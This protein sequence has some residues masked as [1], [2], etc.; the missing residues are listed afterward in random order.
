MAI[1]INAK[2]Y[3]FGTDVP[4]QP[5][6][7]KRPSGTSPEPESSKTTKGGSG[8]GLDLGG[9][10]NFLRGLDPGGVGNV[11]RGF[12][13]ASNLSNGSLKDKEAIAEGAS[14]LKSLDPAGLGKYSDLAQQGLGFA[15]NVKSGS[16]KGTDAAVAGLNLAG[17]LDP[18]GLGP[19][20]N[21]AG[22]GIDL[23]KNVKNGSLK[24]TDAAVASL[25][26]AG[27]LDP[28]G[29]GQYANIAGQGIDFAKNV[30]SGS[31][32]GADA[33]VSGLGLAGQFDPD[34]LGK[35]ANVAGQGLSFAKDV[36]SGSLQGADAAASGLNLAG[37]VIGGEVGQK[38][39][40]GGDIASKVSSISANTVPGAATGNVIGLGFNALQL[41][42]IKID[43][44]VSSLANLGLSLAAGPVGWIG[45]VAQIVSSLFS[46]GDHNKTV[47]MQKGI[48]A[49]GRIPGDEDE[50][51][52]EDDAP[53]DTSSIFDHTNTGFL[54]IGSSHSSSM[55]YDT[56]GGTIDPRLL[57]D[58]EF[59][60]D[61]GSSGFLG[62]GS[63]KPQLT[64]K[65]NY[66]GI[67]PATGGTSGETKID[68]SPE[69][70]QAYRTALGGESG[71]IDP[72]DLQ[73]MAVVQPQ[74]N[75]M[76][77]SFKQK[78]N[79]PTL[80]NYKDVNG[81]GI[82]D[83]IG[84]SLN[85][86]GLEKK[87]DGSVSI[88]ILDKD[89]HQVGDTLTANSSSKIEDNL[90][91]A[92]EMQQ[93]RPLL[94]TYSASHIETWDGGKDLTSTY[95]AL[96]ANGGLE[97]LKQVGPA[98]AEYMQARQTPG[99]DVRQPLEKLNG[100]S[101]EL[102]LGFNARA[103]A[104][105]NPDLLENIGTDPSLLAEH[106]RNHGNFE[107]RALNLNGD[108]APQWINPA[109]RNTTVLGSEI[110]SEPNKNAEIQKGQSLVSANGKFMATMQ[111]DGNF[112]VYDISGKDKKV[113]WEAK[114]NEQ[115]HNGLF[116]GHTT[117][118]ADRMAIQSDGNLA[119]H[120]PGQ[121]QWASDTAN[122]SVNRSFKL[123]MQDDG[124]LVVKDSQGGANLWSSRPIDTGLASVASGLLAGG[125]GILK[126]KAANTDG[127][128]PA[129]QAVTQ[130]PV[131]Y[132]AEQTRAA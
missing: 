100:L 11:E 38:L 109:L 81:D 102:G 44:G 105:A 71:K 110:T 67:N 114:T 48:N 25:N 118:A 115:R 47:E 75:D 132:G 7:S 126:Q 30:K 31:L 50:D 29:L 119:A 93:L 95:R 15:N 125:R 98:M 4:P 23:A 40:L 112:V 60:V 13:F 61:G 74:L 88:T 6:A 37:N 24:G 106:Y 111:A 117:P 130:A 78:E 91:E 99:A 92:S 41:A 127:T 65:A 1:N 108:K 82:P 2:P 52:V 35:Y 59:K 104:A 3:I 9:A 53:S 113:M 94:E 72:K 90:K 17:Q 85:N 107:G 54:S 58:V 5:A 103:Y 20:A 97:K 121:T 84:V 42:G 16:L 46:M 33:A 14:V 128:A 49:T 77:L 124:N 101:K 64:I 10:M 8:S 57:K 34:G 55:Q 51:G 86:E 43:P 73:K 129:F 12:K 76:K 70:V 87:G 45:G 28:G 66:D 96:K 19:Y 122:T 120:S 18:G 21:L 63:S 116:G 32:K 36:N 83:R 56:T 79:D 22:Q 26:L 89:R 80:Y 62:I 39:G 69:Q 123:A 131:S 27:Q 68:L